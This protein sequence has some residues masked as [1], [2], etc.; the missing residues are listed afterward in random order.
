MK[1]TFFLKG[2]TFV[3]VLSSD[4]L[5]YWFDTFTYHSCVV[6]C[7]FVFICLICGKLVLVKCVVVIDFY[8]IDSKLWQKPVFQVVT[9]KHK[10]SIVSKDIINIL[11]QVSCWFYY[12]LIGN[13]YQYREAS[14]F[15][16]FSVLFF[17]YISIKKDDHWLYI[18]TKPHDY[19]DAYLTTSHL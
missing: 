11:I 7:F 8:I 10:C 19:H 4:W 17:I 6:K 14:G 2:T 9:V 5:N 1:G 16:A 12:R 18:D 3:Y 13:N 15:V